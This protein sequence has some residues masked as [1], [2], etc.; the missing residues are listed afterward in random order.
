VGD[1]PELPGLDPA[2]EL[3][4]DLGVRGFS[5]S[6]PERCFEDRAAVFYS[7]SLEDMIARPGHGPLRLDLRVPH[8][9]L[10]MFAR[11]SDH[12]VGLMAILGG[13]FAVSL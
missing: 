4:P 8:L 5:Q 2:L 12:T 10:P 6:A 3:L 7:R 13:Q 11:L 1:F 9:V